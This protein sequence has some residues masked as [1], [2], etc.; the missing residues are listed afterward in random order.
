MGHQ[1]LWSTPESVHERQ[2]ALRGAG[3]LCLV[4]DARIDNRSELTRA[5][6]LPAADGT[7]DADLIVEAY[8]RWGPKCAERLVGDFAFALWDGRT[9]MLFCARDAMGVKPF[10]YFV[11]DTLF[12]FASEAKALLTLPEV[13]HDVDPLEIASFVDGSTEDRTRTIYKAIR[14]LPAAHTLWIGARSFVQSRYWRPDGEREL[15]LSNSD[16]YA[17][18][19][20]ELFGEAVRARMRSVHRVGAALSGG[21]DSSSIVCMAR[22]GG[23]VDS[24]TPLQ[25]FSLVFPTL[26]DKDRRLIDERKYI[27]SVLRSVD[28]Q[29]TFVHGDELSPVADID[30]ILDQMDEPFAAPNLYLHWSMYKAAQAAGV[31][32]FLDGF[33][34][35]TTV[36]HGFARL[37][38]LVRSGQWDTFE[39]EVRALSANRSMP[40][41]RMLDHFGLPYLSVLARRG[42]WAQ[43]AH[44]SRE[45]RRR[46]GVSA[47]RMV[48]EYAMRP[49]LPARLRAAYRT[50]RRSE[51]R[52]ECL[53][54]PE[55][56][57]ALVRRGSAQRRDADSEATWTERESHVEALSHPAYQLTLEIADK[58]AA[59]FGVEPRYPFFDRRLIDFCVAVPDVEKLA[60]GWPRLVFR[61]A[62]AGILPPD[63]RWRSDKGNLSPNFHRSLRSTHLSSLD[64]GSQ[65]VLSPY[66]DPTALAALRR[67]YCAA[68]TTLGR[69]ADGHTLYR[70]LVLQRWLARNENLSGDAS[71]PNTQQASAAA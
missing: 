1:M 44:T 27:D 66:V 4:A 67:R 64:T 53:L 42:E 32:V 56:A 28:V 11:S 46:F 22:R 23:V 59:S 41:Q 55:L 50:L 26:P 16:D 70:V 38:A 19:F 52:A 37:H 65:S 13:S 49:A 58:C 21:L 40:P 6:G 10:Y 36:S 63:V 2:P 17:D 9:E 43:W 35:D 47:R 48:V 61:R 12:A 33:D 14:R 69:S 20:R 34:G 31:R 45:L 71:Q 51:T 15:R 30:D 29:E 3:V 57:M 39:R 24:T 25:T 7:C 5:L 62:M 68:T 54:R 18:A 60:G 8:Y